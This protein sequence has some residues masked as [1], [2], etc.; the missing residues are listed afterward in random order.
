MHI[1]LL[2]HVIIGRYNVQGHHQVMSMPTGGT[3]Q[4]IMLC[5]TCT[6]MWAI[7]H[8]PCYI[9]PSQPT[10]VLIISDYS[11]ITVWYLHVPVVMLA[12]KVISLANIIVCDPVHE[13]KDHE[14]TWKQNSRVSIYNTWACTTCDICAC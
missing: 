11:A 3:P 12:F 4:L 2:F 5:Y 10:W 1:L 6:A 9:V 14:H 8:Q 13:V 7:I